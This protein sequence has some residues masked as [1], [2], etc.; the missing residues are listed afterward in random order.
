VPVLLPVPSASATAVP[1]ED[2]RF[3]QAGPTDGGLKPKP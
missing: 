3:N 2:E 1:V